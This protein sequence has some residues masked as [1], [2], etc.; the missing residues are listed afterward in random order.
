MQTSNSMLVNK[1]LRA[2]RPVFYAFGH[3]LPVSLLSVFAFPYS[4]SFQQFIQDTN[5]SHVCGSSSNC[6]VCNSRCRLLTGKVQAAQ[7]SALFPNSG[8][9]V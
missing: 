2:S 8:M 6:S 7:E 1:R 9:Y 5:I 3:V 4:N